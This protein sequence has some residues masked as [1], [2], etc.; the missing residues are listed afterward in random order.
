MKNID[1]IVDGQF[2]QDKKMIDLI[3]RGSYNQKK[4]DVQESIKN[5]RTRYLEFGDEYR[6]KEKVNKP[7]MILIKAFSN[8]ISK[9][10]KIIIEQN[11]FHIITNNSAENIEKEYINI[12]ELEKISA[13]NYIKIATLEK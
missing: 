3:A 6:I 9:E 1:I 12:K 7:K 13:E 5:G 8:D 10:Q 11:D 4:I 2:I